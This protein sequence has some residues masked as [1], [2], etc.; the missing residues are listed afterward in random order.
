MRNWVSASPAAD[1]SEFIIVLT[2][3][4]LYQ[5]EYPFNDAYLNVNVIPKAIQGQTSLSTFMFSI[6]YHP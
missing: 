1:I 6:L 5:T 4:L 2:L 3:S